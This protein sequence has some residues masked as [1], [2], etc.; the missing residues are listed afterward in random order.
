M[1]WRTILI[2]NQIQVLVMEKFKIEHFKR[3]NPS[4][5][6]PAFKTLTPEEARDVYESVL[7]AMGW[8]V[9]PERLVKMI[10]ERGTLVRGVNATEDGFDLESIFDDLGI[11]PC[12]KVYLNW[13]RFDEIDEMSF[14][15]VDKYFDDIW[16][17]GPDDMDIFDESFSWIV[18][19]SHEGYVTCLI[20][21]ER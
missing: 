19:V 8:D 12:E 21:G 10:Y 17:P 2:E 18:S 15:D 6:F 7:K 11:H 14:A 20:V 1:N 9:S 4:N 16:Y 5:E 3:E 13:Y